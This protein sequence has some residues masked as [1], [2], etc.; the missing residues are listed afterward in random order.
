[1]NFNSRQC[2]VHV[3]QQRR[4]EREREMRKKIQFGYRYSM[5]CSMLLSVLSRSN[6]AGLVP[7]LSSGPRPNGA[8]LLKFQPVSRLM[9]M[10]TFLSAH[11][12]PPMLPLI[13]AMSSTSQVCK[14]TIQDKL[15]LHLSSVQHWNRG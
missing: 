11:S 1:M 9:P 14:T 10:G 3:L 5:P 15:W 6:L 4:V 8:P 12:N 13:L 7:N 2:L